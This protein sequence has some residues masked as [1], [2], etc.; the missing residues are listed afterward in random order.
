[1]I[2]GGTGT[3][4]V[5][6]SPPA[7][8]LRAG[9]SVRLNTAVALCGSS[10]LGKAMASRRKATQ[11]LRRPSAVAEQSQMLCADRRPLSFDR[12]LQAAVQLHIAEIR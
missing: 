4:D 3:Q 8:V 6:T 11:A 9:P 1:M 7:A 2:A 10:T 12:V 5:L